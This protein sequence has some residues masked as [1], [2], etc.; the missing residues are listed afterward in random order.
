MEN[1]H[2][3]KKKPTGHAGA[4]FTPLPPEAA[5]LAQQMKAAG[6]EL[7]RFADQQYGAKAQAGG[8]VLIGHTLAEATAWFAS[9][10]RTTAKP[11]PS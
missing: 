9:Q 8:V 7:V 10:G 4:S 6:Q 1:A 11:S 5:P 2:M 3:T